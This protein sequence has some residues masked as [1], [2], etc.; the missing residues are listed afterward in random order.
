[1][2]PIP[3]LPSHMGD[4]SWTMATINM[5]FFNVQKI[6]LLL[7]PAFD[8]HKLL[9]FPPKMKP[10]MKLLHCCRQN[11]L[12][13]LLSLLLNPPLVCPSTNRFRKKFLSK[14]PCLQTYRMKFQHPALLPLFL[15]K[16]LNHLS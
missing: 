8:Q 2:T 7:T 3:S 6:F 13:H 16:I 9:P 4:R 5:K 10:E 12:P 15:K 11:L 1:M 14:K